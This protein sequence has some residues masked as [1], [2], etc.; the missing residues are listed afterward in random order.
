MCMYNFLKVKE[1]FP[2]LLKKSNNL[3]GYDLF[4]EK[5]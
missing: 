5:N 3:E 1:L 2:S 4:A